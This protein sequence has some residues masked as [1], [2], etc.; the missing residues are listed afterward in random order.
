MGYYFPGAPQLYALRESRTGSWSQINS[1]QS[2]TPITR[3]YFSLAFEHGTK[4]ANASYA[5]VLLPGKDAAATAAYS[6]NPQVEIMSNT[7]EL[8]AV[9]QKRLGM[10]AANFWVPGTI[11]TITAKN[12]ASVM[13]KQ[14][15][16]EITLA[17]SDPTQQQSTITVELRQAGLS[18]VAK[19]D[20]VQVAQNGG[21]TT[22]VADVKG[23]IGRTHTVTFQNVLPSAGSHRYSGHEWPAKQ[24]KLTADPKK[25]AALIK[26][27]FLR[28]RKGSMQGTTAQN[29]PV[30]G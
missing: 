30:F 15:G 19:D 27:A 28:L 24:G 22:I 11:G 6:S 1:G 2:K 7:A 12:P 23:S 16:G 14:T 13:L 17:L 21:I 20:S 18:A 29:P 26:A 10:T 8:Q 3:N 25:N 9:K 4:P 5:Y